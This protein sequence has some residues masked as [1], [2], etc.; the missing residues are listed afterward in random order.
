MNTWPDILTLLSLI[1]LLGVGIWGSIRD[2]KKQ[3]AQDESRQ[4]YRPEP[5]DKRLE[6]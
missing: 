2:H 5:F 6:K 3:K 1:A 4:S